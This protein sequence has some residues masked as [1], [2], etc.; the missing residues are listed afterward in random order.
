VKPRTRETLAI[1]LP[2]MFAEALVVGFALAVLI[3]KVHGS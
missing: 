3:V 2:V 1:T